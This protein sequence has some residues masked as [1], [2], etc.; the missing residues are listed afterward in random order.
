MR[1]LAGV[2]D[3]VVEE[4]TRLNR[5]SGEFYWPIA[6]SAG[7]DLPHVLAK[8]KPA[9]KGQLERWPEL[10]AYRKQNESLA[11]WRHVRPYL[12]WVKQ[13]VTS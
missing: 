13:A 6:H 2:G 5:E 9:T 1:V 7:N 11:P 3:G 10:A 12:L 8:V 4:A